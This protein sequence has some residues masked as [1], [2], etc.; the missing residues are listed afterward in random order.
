MTMPGFTAEVS[1][2]KVTESF[3]LTSG[4]RAEAGSVIPQYDCIKP[5][6]CVC[7]GGANSRDCALMKLIECDT[8][9]DPSADCDG[10]GR[11]FCSVYEVRL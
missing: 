9:V 7:Y 2:G 10:L 6:Y 11:C 8:P 5:G 3:L 1:L 4:A